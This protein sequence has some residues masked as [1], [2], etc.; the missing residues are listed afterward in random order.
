MKI[1]LWFA[2]ALV[3]M[4]ALTYGVLVSVSHRGGEKTVSDGRIETV[5]NN[6]D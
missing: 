1:T 5:E 6:V 3:L 4:V 2:G